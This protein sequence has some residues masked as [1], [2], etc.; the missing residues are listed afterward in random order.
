MKKCILTI[1]AGLALAGFVLAA[2]HPEHPKAKTPA[3]GK[4]SAAS[5]TKLDGKVFAGKIIKQGTEQGDN[6]KFVF[7][8]GTFSSTVAA[9]DGFPEAPYTATEYSGVFSFSAVSTKAAG[10]TM[11]W[12]GTI[13]KNVIGGI[14]VRSTKAGQIKY[15]F[16]GISATRSADQTRENL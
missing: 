1:A 8:K 13:V 6:D 15:S 7:Q 16:K 11:T 12:Q 2:E 4:H 5:N 10:E 9:A 3:A 14:A